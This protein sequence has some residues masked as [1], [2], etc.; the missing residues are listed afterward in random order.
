MDQ[1]IEIHRTVRVILI[2]LKHNLIARVA[3]SGGGGKTFGGI[4]DQK[5]ARIILVCDRQIDPGVG[6]KCASGDSIGGD[7]SGTI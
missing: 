2:A 7:E 5:C 3:R 4:G 6:R 1:N